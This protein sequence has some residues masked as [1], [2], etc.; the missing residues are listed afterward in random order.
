MTE[1]DPITVEVIR[2]ALLTAAQEMKAVVVRTAYSTLWREAGDLSCGLLTSNC[3]IVAQGAG[4][5]PV[6]LGTMPI[7]ARGCVDGIR[8]PIVDGDILFCNDPY[9]GNNHLPDFLMLKPVFAGTTL[10][11]YAAVRGHYVDIGG[12]SPGSH[13]AFAHDIYAEGLRYPPMKL[14]RTGVRNEEL[15]TILQANTRGAQERLGDLAAQYAGCLMGERRLQAL[16]KKYG[17]ET[18]VA[19]MERV[20]DDSEREMRRQITTLP[21][22]TY[23]FTDWCDNDGVTTEPIR[24]QVAVM[25]EGDKVS[26]DFEGSGPQVRGAVN[27]PIAVTSSATYYAFKCLLDPLNPA[28]SGQYRP[29]EIRAPLGSILNCTPPAPVILGNTETA[30]RIVDAIL[31]AMAD[32]VPDRVVAAGSGSAT[33]YIIAGNDSRPERAGRHF[34]YLEPHGS[35]H[36]ASRDRDGT[37]GTRVG[38]GN[39]GNT[40]TEG[41]EINFP[42]RVEAYELLTDVGGAGRRRG[43]CSVRHRIRFQ[44]PVSVVMCSERTKFPPYGLDGARPGAKARVTLEVPGKPIQVLGSKTDSIHCPADSVIEVRAAGGGGY[45]DPRTREPELVAADVMDDYVSWREA[46]RSYGVKLAPDVR[47][48]YDATRASRTRRRPVAPKKGRR[49]P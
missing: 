2:N 32:V 29:V 48:G 42:L 25:V 14:Y 9:S 43:G 36:G 24:I 41:V 4:D 39:T 27:C 31:G 16:A 18:V 38:V 26:V 37:S 19:T 15:V 22:G 30:Y 44:T 13:S 47:G 3:E 11:G 45:G 12:H 40:S 1:L 10:L 34:I 23:R 7:S 49:K 33:T 28:N 5:I 17:A 21:P 46:E 6:H 8:E 20:L 35:G